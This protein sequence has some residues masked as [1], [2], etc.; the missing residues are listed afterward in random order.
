LST[1]T[2]PRTVLSASRLLG[3]VRSRVGASVD[4]RGS[5]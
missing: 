4:T 2:A 5:P 1:R 3:S